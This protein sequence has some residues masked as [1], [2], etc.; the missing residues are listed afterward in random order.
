MKVA[1]IKDNKLDSD[2]NAPF[3]SSKNYL[4]YRFK[5]IQIQLFFQ[6]FGEMTG[7]IKYC[8]NK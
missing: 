8:K 7:K 1:I 5:E 3:N 2:Y 6:L 4:K